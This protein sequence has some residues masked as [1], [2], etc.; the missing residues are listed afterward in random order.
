MRRQDLAVC[1]IAAIAALGLTYAIAP[2]QTL[3]DKLRAELTAVLAQLHELQNNEAGLQA[4]KAAAERDRDALKAKLAKLGGGHGAPKASPVAQAALAVEKTKDDQL[5]TGL[6]QAQAD[7][8]K[9]KDALAQAEQAAQQAR[10]ERDRL[11]V[12]VNTGGA[13]LADCETM[14]IQLIGIGHEILAAYGKVGVR[15]VVERGEPLLGL[16]R[17]KLERVAQAYGDRIYGAKFD[18]RAVKTPP[19]ATTTH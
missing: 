16:E 3:D 12:Q 1:A 13:A 7:L 9:Y 4:E 17:A 18:P 5:T 6:Q 11:A 2:A 14:N 15:Q 19:P 10:A 8:A